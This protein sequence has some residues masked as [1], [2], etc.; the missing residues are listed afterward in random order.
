LTSEGGV[1][2]SETARKILSLLLEQLK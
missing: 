1:G 2:R